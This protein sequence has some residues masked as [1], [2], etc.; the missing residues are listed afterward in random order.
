MSSSRRRPDVRGLEDRQHSFLPKH[1]T[2]ALE[3]ELLAAHAEDPDE[4]LELRLLP[5]LLRTDTALYDLWR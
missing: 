3:E 5:Q 4:L 1:D 2:K